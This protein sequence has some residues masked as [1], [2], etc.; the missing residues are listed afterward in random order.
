MLTGVL[1]VV[2]RSTVVT[3]V[4]RRRRAMP[5]NVEVGQH[6]IKLPYAFVH[7]SLHPSTTVTITQL[8]FNFHH[9]PRL[10]PLTFTQHILGGAYTIWQEKCP[11]C[12]GVQNVD[13]LGGGH[14]L[15]DGCGDQLSSEIN[16]FIAKNPIGS[17]KAKL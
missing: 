16:S 2:G 14:F 5:W 6:C 7:S 1:V 15:Q 8:P 3:C 17:S 12:K 4:R 9:G 11:A 10:S 13:M